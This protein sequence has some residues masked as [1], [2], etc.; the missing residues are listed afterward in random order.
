MPIDF[1]SIDESRI[2]RESWE[3][4]RNLHNQV[5]EHRIER[6]GITVR[7]TP[8]TIGAIQAIDNEITTMGRAFKAIET[9]VI[10]PL[11][12]DLSKLR[13]ELTIE[14][15]NELYRVIV[16]KSGESP[17]A[18]E[19]VLKYK[20]EYT[21]MIL[22]GKDTHWHAELFEMGYEDIM[23]LFKMLKD[24]SKMLD[25][26][27]DKYHVENPKK[28][29]EKFWDDIQIMMGDPTSAMDRWRKHERESQLRDKDNDEKA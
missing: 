7:F 28:K 27:S 15:A 4:F 23:Q 14:E 17:N 20:N 12:S 6:L 21:L 2:T 18:E 5:Y 3:E 13:Q 29:D 10:E 26:L 25:Y 8:L 22:L 1:D 16:E 9:A 19:E 24:K 11:G